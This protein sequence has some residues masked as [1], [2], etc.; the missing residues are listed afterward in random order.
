MAQTASE[1]ILELLY[2]LRLIA[3]GFEVGHEPEI[4]HVNLVGMGF[5]V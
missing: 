5:E 1:P 4:G 2:R 3:C